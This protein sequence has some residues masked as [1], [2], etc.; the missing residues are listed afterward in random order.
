MHG[1]TTD[2]DDRAGRP[3][4]GPRR[5]LL[6][7]PGRPRKAALALLLVAA[8]AVVYAPV[9]EHAFLEHGDATFFLENPVLAERL[10]LSSVERAFA[11]VHEGLWIPLTW[12]SYELDRTLYGGAPGPTLATNVALHAVAAVLLF[13]ALARMTGAVG[14]SG[15][16]AALFALHPLQVES[17]AWASQRKDVL[18]MVFWSLSLYLYARYAD[19]EDVLRRYQLMAFTAVLGLLASPLLV[20]LPFALLLLDF[21]P[22][23]RMGP[24]GGRLDRRLLRESV[25]EKLQ[26]IAMTVVIGGVTLA[27]R[28]GALAPSPRIPVS[29]RLEGAFG[30]IVARLGDA[31]WPVGLTP[32]E[33][34]RYL[35]DPEAAASGLVAA[36][37]AALLVAVTLAATRLS[38]AHPYLLVGWLWVLGTLAPAFVLELLGIPARAD[39][40]AYLPLVGV[41]ILVAWGVPELLPSFRGRGAALALAA[42]SALGALST[43]SYRQVGFWRDDRALAERAL[44]VDERSYEAHALFARVALREGRIEDAKRG[45]G[46]AAKLAPGWATPLV[47]LG[48]LFAAEGKRESALRGYQLAFQRDPTSALAASKIGALLAGT[49]RLRQALRPLELAVALGSTDPEVHVQLALAYAR[50]GEPEK[51]IAHNREALRLRPGLPNALNN[52]AWMLATH[53]REQIRAPEE[54]VAMAE[55]AA[56]ATDDAPEM[57][58]TLAAAYAAAG[59]FEEATQTARR[60]ATAAAEAGSDRLGA[61]IVSRLAL[62]EQGLA[63]VERLDGAAEPLED[64][65]AREVPPAANAPGEAS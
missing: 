44:E 42:L 57:L 23:G 60:A 32:F 59:R 6:G 63:Y 28:G 24:A 25:T 38:R 43:A 64:R 19:G 26:L 12:I 55:Q 1:G 58:D 2:A 16:V 31:F 21:W 27:Q 41:G 13:F 17:V 56:L 48:D 49:G 65:D 4:P 10:T 53:P 62:Y 61:Q 3:P 37:S 35:L 5:P 45:L 50:H 34:H 22:L 36:S 18:A 30:G 47:E 52:L 40:Y 8:L 20:P 29:H 11:A 15:F 46:N 14:R 51:A 54:A 9:R 39:R 33:P 7:R